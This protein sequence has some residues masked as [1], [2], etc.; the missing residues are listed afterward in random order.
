MR[1]HTTPMQKALRV[2]RG[3]RLSVGPML[4]ELQVSS[5]GAN[6][7]IAIAII[8]IIIIIIRMMTISPQTHPNKLVKKARRAVIG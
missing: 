7:V 1:V 2:L 5:I 3:A 8:Q 4:P 6:S